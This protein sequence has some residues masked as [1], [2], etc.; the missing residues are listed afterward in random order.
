MVLSLQLAFLCL[1]IIYAVP[2]L[3]ITFFIYLNKVSARCGAYI[4]CKQEIMQ[5]NASI[6]YRF[7]WTQF[8]SNLMNALLL[9]DAIQDLPEVSREDTFFN[10]VACCFNRDHVYCLLQTKEVIRCGS[11]RAKL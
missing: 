10:C 9:G 4:A 8:P 2:I 7:I 1:V 3:H 11:V 6:K 5:P